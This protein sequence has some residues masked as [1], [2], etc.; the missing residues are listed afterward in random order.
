MNFE[1]PVAAEQFRSELRQFLA[2][3]IPA[4]WK[5]LFADDERVYPF[6]HQLCQKLAARGWLTMA[7]PAKF[8]GADADVWTQMVVREEMW[9][10]GEPRGPQYMNLNYIGPMIM[11]FGTTEQQERFL[12]PMA[13]GNVMWC[14]GFSEPGSGSDLA[15]LSI[16]ATD[17]GECFIVNG[18]KIWSSYATVADWCLLLVR[19][20]SNSKRHK[21][22]SMLIVDMKTPGITVRPIPSMGGPAEFNELFF[23]HVKVP[24]DS[25]L[26]PRDA[27]WSV[28]MWALAHERVGIAWHS[29]LKVVFDKL[30]EYVKTTQDEQG[31]ALSERPSVRA[32]LVRLHA[33]YRAARLLG[34]RVI[35]AQEAGKGNDMDPA[36]YKVFAT[37]AA[38]FAGEIGLDMM[39]SKGQLTEDDPQAPLKGY[40]FSHWIHSIPMLIAAGSNEI[41]RNIISQRGLGLPR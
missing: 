1:Y 38:V 22:L 21:G 6:T 32:G 34:Y 8:G 36:I 5:T 17:T 2:E 19:T 27:G 20:D 29:R 33:R 16:R 30:V 10:I 26:G 15:S 4:W 35:S 13:A 25:L 7:W 41:Q 31:R 14:Q 12:K 37:E 23:D 39:G 28:A 40:L 24:Y 3:E 11:Q 18:Q 9:A